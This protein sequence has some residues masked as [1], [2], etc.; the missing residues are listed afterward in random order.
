MHLAYGRCCTP[1]C[2]N[3]SYLTW[4]YPCNL[5]PQGDGRRDV[6]LWPECRSLMSR[7]VHETSTEGGTPAALAGPRHTADR[8]RPPTSP[9]ADRARQGGGG[10]EPARRV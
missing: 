10:R 1:D 6:R 7:S 2:R 5:G 9:R 8:G 4:S 3:C